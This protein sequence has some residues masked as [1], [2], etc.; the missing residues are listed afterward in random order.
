[1]K[2]FVHLHNHSEFSLLDGIATVGKIAKRVSE[3]GMPA[4]ALTDHGVMYG[5]I[6]FY[7]AMND[8][9]VKPI[10]G[11]EVYMARR[12]MS[13]RD[14]QIDRDHFHLTLLARNLDG[15]RN[16]MKLVSIAHCD[17][18]FYKPRIDFETLAVHKDGLICLSGCLNGPIAK[19]F[20]NEG[21]DA[22][23]VLVDRFARLFGGDYYIEIQRHGI[24]EEDRARAY[25]IDAA[26]RKGIRLAA[27]N[28]CHYI[29]K[30]DAR[31]HDIAL[32]IN[33]RK[34]VDDDERLR[35][36]EKEYYIKTRD[37]MDA[38]FGDVPDALD[39]TVEIADMIDFTLPLG[40][41]TFPNFAI[42]EGRSE[43]THAELLR[44]LVFEGA[45]KRFGTP[46]QNDIIERLNHELEVIE[47]M[48]YST[49][50]LIVWDFIR[51][52]RSRDIAVGPGRGSGA[53]SCVA[54]CLEITDV[55]P[56]EFNL[57]FE[58][59]LNKDRVT[60][61][62]FDIDFC[63]NRREKV[64]EYVKEKYGADNVAQIITFNHLKAKAVIKAVGRVMNLPFHYVNQVTKTIPYGI[65]MTLETALRESPDLVRMMDED[66][67]VA[68]LIAD[69]AKLEGLASHGGVH[70]AG[71]VIAKGR[72]EDYVPVQKAADSDMRVAQY[73]LTVIEDAGLVKM[74]F[75]GLRTLTMLEEA[76]K[77]VREF[78]G[79][80]I[81]LRKLPLDDEKTYRLFQRGDTVGVFQFERDAVRRVLRD[82]QP[83]NI[84][85]ISTIN[86]LNRPGP[87]S[88]T[89]T[90]IRNRRNPEF[91]EYVIPELRDELAETAGVVIYQE[92]VMLACRKLAGFTMGEADIM[93]WAMGKKKIKKMEEMKVKFIEGCIANGYTRNHANHWFALIET[94]AGYGFN[95]CHSLPYSILSYQTAYFRAHY[96]RHFITAVINSYLGDA[97]TTRQYI[98]EARSMGF[99]VY[100][101]DVN[102]SVYEFRPEGDGIRFGL[103]G[104]K[105]IGRS[106]IQAIHDAR[107]TSEFKSVSDFL[108]RV[109]SRAVTKGVLEALIK[110]GA[111]DELDNIRAKLLADI[112]TLTDKSRDPRQGGLF[113]GL[114]PEPERSDA[115]SARYSRVEIAEME[116]DVLGVYLAWHPLEGAAVLNDP[117]LMTPTRFYEWFNENL[118]TVSTNRQVE[119]GGVLANIEF[120]ISR[121]GR[122]YAR[123]RLTDAEEFVTLLIFE[124]TLKNIRNL[125]VTKNQVRVVGTMNLENLEADD[126]DE[127][128]PQSKDVTVYVNELAMYESSNASDSASAQDESAWKSS[129]S[130]GEGFARKADA[131]VLVNAGAVADAVG[132]AAD[133][134]VL[135]IPASAL[136]K[137][138]M[139][140]LAAELS[141]ARDG[142]SNVTLAIADGNGGIRIVRLPDDIRV[143]QKRLKVIAARFGLTVRSE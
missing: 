75:L 82:A 9:G 27:T 68:E 23:D 58:R 117:N 2:P 37:E 124:N 47:D 84:E 65:N 74:D 115:T 29:L 57:I 33:T 66:E 54:Y 85:D 136:R 90:Y 108:T 137:L 4:F 53:G 51:F 30:E 14:A 55:D 18:M 88:Y 94:F 131:A 112:N 120:A 72:L 140:E 26:R 105:G 28:D 45:I 10:I 83:R 67:K 106:A 39:A 122:E 43:E 16:L 102:M 42:P 12:R 141:L 50:F 78:E 44:N 15:Y 123:A 132:E 49:Y 6:P 126:D 109:D 86:G 87:A 60:L 107:A 46:V 99:E 143:E 118:D 98:A 114:T 113:G 133:T 89:E 63:M 36:D 138:D 25:L 73:D 142:D 61:P 101:P 24:A 21:E 81:D 71:V 17:G 127:G 91:A 59:F 70:A 38:L 111:F 35:Y 121:N 119:L 97:K 100:K 1:M 56:I 110:A 22:A 7:R 79:V 20:L 129:Q 34:G 76:V 130:A 93:R 134:L 19:T 69:A 116:Y 3:L 128:K 8:A 62:D 96:P 52:A 104:I 139:H 13:D 32:C 31:A 92:Q 125:L 48:G 77:L 95:K 11:C 5:V 41:V 64:I 40:K 135:E 103:A 80:E